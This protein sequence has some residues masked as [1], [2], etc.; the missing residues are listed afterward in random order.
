MNASIIYQYMSCPQLNEPSPKRPTFPVARLSAHLR[1][2][3]SPQADQNVI[4]CFIFQFVIKS[5]L[6]SKC[7]LNVR[8]CIIRN[9]DI[10]SDEFRFTRPFVRQ[11]FGEMDF[12]LMCEL[13]IVSAKCFR[14]VIACMPFLVR[15]SSH[16]LLNAHS[17][18]HKKIWLYF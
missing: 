7:R 8:I 17:I 11:P 14:T 16:V 13:G 9:A 4:Q 15:M 18:R 5:L 12:L 2:R 1:L 3:C 10:I 6:N